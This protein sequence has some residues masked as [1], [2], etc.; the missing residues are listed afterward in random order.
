MECRPTTKGK[1]GNIARIMSGGFIS[2]NV[3]SGYFR[4]SIA[5]FKQNLMEKKLGKNLS[6]QKGKKKV[7]YFS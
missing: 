3:K 4:I 1:K 7:V 6:K 2:L 5:N